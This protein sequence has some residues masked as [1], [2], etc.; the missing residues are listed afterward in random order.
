M[1]VD[2]QRE[3]LEVSPSIALDALKGAFS[4]VADA[5]NPV[6]G[7]ALHAS[8]SFVGGVGD[9]VGAELSS[10]KGVCEVVDDEEEP[11]PFSEVSVSKTSNKRNICI[12]Y[13][14]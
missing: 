3:A 10:G 1:P 2:C 11:H 7:N 12:P 5:L 4:S 14:R 13:W 8:V 6:N 9:G